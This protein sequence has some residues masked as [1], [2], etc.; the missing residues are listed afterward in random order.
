MNLIDNYKNQIIELCDNHKVK[1]LYL[2]GSIL[3]DKFNDSSDID[4][5]IQ[6]HQV[7]LLDYFD[8]YMDLKEK[9]E[10][11]LNRPV[12]LLE[13]QAIRNPIFRQVLDREKRL[14]Y[15]RKNS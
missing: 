15:E 8:N 5:L 9:L 4:M 6:F 7:E 1:E 12:D 10:K 3:T 11:V 13:N 2:F 14:F